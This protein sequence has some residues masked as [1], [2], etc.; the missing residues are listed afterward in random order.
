MSSDRL[1]KAL[2][3][4][5]IPLPAEAELRGLAVVEAAY[6]ERS[7]SRPVDGRLRPS[8]PRLA[9]ALAIATLL[10]ALL[11]S[12][13]GAAVRDW[14]GDVVDNAPRPERGLAEIPGGGHLLVQSATGPWVVQPDGSRRLLG[15]YEE[16]DWSPRGLY[17]AVAAGRTLSA[18]EPGGTPHW[19][20][21]APRRVADPRWSPSGYRIAY[22]SGR[23]LRIVA[24]DGTGDH[25][26][27]PATQPVAPAWSP[28]GTPE[29]A[30]VNAEGQ[31]RIAGSEIRASR[32]GVPSDMAGAVTGPDVRQ[33]EWGAAGELI[34]EVSPGGLHLQRMRL[35]KLEGRSEFGPRTALDIPSGAT[36]VD[37]ALNPRQATVA[38]VLT[39]WRP[40]GTR[41]SVVVF[42]PG[43]APRRLLTVPGSLGEVA[44]SPDGKRLLVAWP[45]ANE[46]LFLPIGRGQG[47]AVAG[48]SNAFAP[49]G[50]K[51]SFP[52]VEGWCCSR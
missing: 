32:R 50:R 8:M 25:L 19:S 4:A 15:D 7:G 24:G 36:V 16:S 28:F 44:W 23:S 12:P 30:Y 40:T 17:V 46:W 52:R 27:N 2:R 22:R 18:V 41:S 31:L 6:A 37:A 1:G 26:V 39:F 11:L 51:M 38:A 21:T 13:A 9:I 29:L 5:P 48:V 35:N 33:I 20:I 43:G 3:E 10:L 34:L 42:G 49:G 47:R 45:G 14:V